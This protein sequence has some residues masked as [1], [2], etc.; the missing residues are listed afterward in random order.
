M[1]GS[2]LALFL[3][4]QGKPFVPPGAV[5][6]HVD[7][8]DGAPAV[9]LRVVVL[10]VYGTGGPNDNLNTFE[11]STP[12]SKTLTDNE[13][14]F[15]ME[16][17]PPGRYYILAG[18][19]GQG[20]FYPGTSDITKAVRVD[21]R[22]NEETA[23]LNMKMTARY[24][25]RV[26]GSVKADMSQLGPRTATITGPPLQDLLEVPVKPDGSF[27]FGHVPNGTFLLSLYPPTSGISGLRIKVGNTDVS[28]EELIPLPTQNVTGRIIAKKGPVPIGYLAFETDKGNYVGATINPDGT[29]TAQ[30]HSDFHHIEMEGLQVG[31]SIASVT[32]GSQD[33]TN[34]IR[35]DKQDISGI[36]VTLDTPD[37]LSS[38]HGKITGLAPARY[39]TTRVQLTG[40][41]VGALEASVKSDGTFDFP[42]VTPGSYTLKL[43]QVPEFSSL[44]INLD[45]PRLFDISV[46][47]PNQ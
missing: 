47:V 35:V 17:V 37:Q 41:I 46:T 26:T 13:G 29:F 43:T 5:V 19:S 21:V 38:V 14:N 6:G 4:L 8:V 36:L 32:L 11:L 34:G 2:F 31:Y 9:A 23:D 27:D 44:L 10:G 28:G 15:R 18:D 1:F 42:A 39:S 12:V 7:A 25:G 16:D 22:S 30:L 33:I 20:S 24:G 3:L 45:S 40:L